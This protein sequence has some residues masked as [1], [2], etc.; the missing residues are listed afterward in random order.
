MEHEN[1]HFASRGVGNTALGLSIGA[2]GAGLLSGSF[3]NLLGGANCACNEDHYV[4][5]YEATQNA[6]IAELETEVKLRD[7][8]IYCDSKIL[9][10]YRYVDGKFGAVE[11]ELCQQRV[12]NATNTSAIA[13]IQGQVAQLMALTKTVIPADNICPQPMPMYNSWTAP[14]APTT[15]GA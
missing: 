1:T 3:G 14:T 15:A 13:C 4:N 8:N 9:E 12:Y 11:A 6:R 7:S 10:L 2:L 5:R